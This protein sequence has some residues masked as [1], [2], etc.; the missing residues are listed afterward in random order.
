MKLFLVIG[1]GLCLATGFANADTTEVNSDN[2]SEFNSKI[3]FGAMEERIEIE[4]S[5]GWYF[6]PQIGLSMIG[7]VTYPEGKFAINTTTDISFDNG[8][9][10]GVGIGFELGKNIS[11]QL[12]VTTQKNDVNLD[13]NLIHTDTGGDWMISGHL[14]QTPVIL[15]LIWRGGDGESVKPHL[16][17]SIGSTYCDSSLTVTDDGVFRSSGGPYKFGD[18]GWNMSYGFTAGI[19][20]DMSPTSNLYFNYRYLHV[21][22]DDEPLDVH[23]VGIGIS[24]RF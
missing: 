1:T 16:G 11:L 17:V 2:A 7:D 9:F 18:D 24:F 13:T 10:F 5:G 19:G 14:E 12:D 4:D 21:D 20:I 8:L 15:N 23:N 3:S 6:V 22:Y